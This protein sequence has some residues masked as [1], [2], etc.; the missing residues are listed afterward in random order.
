M[1]IKLKPK[2]LAMLQETQNQ[3][4]QIS[5][6]FQELS[7]KEAMILELVFEENGI[8]DKVS[9]VKLLEGGEIEYEIELPKA[10]VKKQKKKAV[11]KPA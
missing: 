9:S 3:K 8:T 6:V 11:D 10:P 2:Q 1:K 7:N 4:T 5:K